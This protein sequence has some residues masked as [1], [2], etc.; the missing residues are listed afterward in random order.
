MN[1]QDRFDAEVMAQLQQENEARWAPVFAALRAKGVAFKRFR[2]YP[3]YVVTEDGRV[4]S[5]RKVR[6]KKLIGRASKKGYLCVRLFNEHGEKH[7]PIHRIVA[8]A[9]LGEP[10][11]PSLVVN[12]K[13]GMKTNN[14]VENLEWCT[15]LENMRHSRAMGLHR[16][17]DEQRA[18]FKAISR[19]RRQL[20]SHEAAAILREY[21]GN[22]GE[23]RVLAA[24]YGVD[25]RVIWKLV[26]RMTYKDIKEAA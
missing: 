18:I 7:F 11:D 19:T 9:F 16:M 1:D 23:Q 2:K 12:H 14:R 26:N 3:D 21:T 4:Y 17:T 10:D 22:R 25:Y 6:I 8:A 20:Q 13:D 5:G 15:N 24:K